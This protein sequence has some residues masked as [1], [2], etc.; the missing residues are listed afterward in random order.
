MLAIDFE[1]GAETAWQHVATFVPKFLGF[2][3]ILI[4]GY[5]LAKILARV[6][7]GIL[8][9]VGFD[10]WV[11]RGAVKQALDRSKFDASDILALITFWAVF[12]IAL[13]L[14][15]GVF[16]P[17]PVSD[18]I[19]GII[20]FLPNIFVA[21]VI[22][23][24]TAALAKVVTEVV[25]ATLGA[26]PGGE[27]MARGAGIAILVIGIFAALNQLQIAPEIVNGLFYAMLA[28]V[29]GSAIVAFGGGGIPVARRYLERA[30]GKL[31][32][33]APEIKR[34][35]QGATDRIEQRAEE[36][37]QEYATPEDQPPPPSW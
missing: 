33:T 10:G 36:M 14:A 1:A 19:Q 22:L 34:Q 30:S 20:A 27:V 2:L 29:V 25:R 12:L 17:N 13:Q 16:G 3:A 24:I 7:D 5:F 37:K 31:E 23:V 32:Q 26:M 4:I 6:V 9:R 28:V 15:F 11:E 21:L 8:E 35:A 18:L